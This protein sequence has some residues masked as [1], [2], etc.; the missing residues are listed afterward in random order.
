MVR[1][2]IASIMALLGMSSRFAA[3][4]AARRRGWIGEDRSY[5]DAGGL[6]GQAGRHQ[7]LRLRPERTL[8]PCEEDDLIGLDCVLVEEGGERAGD[9]AGVAAVLGEGLG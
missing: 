9:G 6:V 8:V 4:G 5:L 2:H 3:G 7:R 1:R